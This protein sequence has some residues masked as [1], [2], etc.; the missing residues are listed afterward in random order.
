MAGAA[1]CSSFILCQCWLLWLKIT[2]ITPSG[3]VVEVCCGS[4]WG[5]F[6]TKWGSPGW[7]K[8]SQT[9]TVNDYH[10]PFLACAC[11]CLC[12]TVIHSAQC[13]SFCPLGVDSAGE[14]TSHK[15]GIILRILLNASS[16]VYDSATVVVLPVHS[17]WCPWWL[18]LIK[19]LPTITTHTFWREIEVAVS[20][21]R[22]WG[23]LYQGSNWDGRWKGERGLDN[24]PHKLL[25]AVQLYPAASATSWTPIIAGKARL[26]REPVTPP[27][28]LSSHPPF[29]PQL[30]AR[31]S[32]V[33]D[34]VW[35]PL[36]PQCVGMCVCEREKDGKEEEMFWTQLGKTPDIA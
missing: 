16:Y 10:C 27:S 6:S 12:I 33:K 22:R 2:L 9:C 24:H 13:V 21:A 1:R 19:P 32:K 35:C 26:V 34:N 4:S 14:L 25:A 28:L 3:G 17:P 29:P 31:N 8:E 23:A 7:R 11:V 5:V 20:M 15:L 30:P 36:Q 18:W